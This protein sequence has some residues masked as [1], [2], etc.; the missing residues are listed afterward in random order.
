MSTPKNL[1]YTA[2]H[3]WIEVDGDKAKIGIT[4]Y[5]STAMGDIVFVDLPEVDDEVE[6]E[7]AI[8]DIESV[9]SVSP[10]ISPVTGKIIAI[11]EALEDEPELIN[12]KP[13]E[14]WI[15]EVEFSEIGDTLTAAE[16]DALEKE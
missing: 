9:K 13:Y 12:A 6:M 2:S 4:E 7:E 1:K 16:Y 15:I 11:N 10:M 3:E 14:S 8:C 5:A